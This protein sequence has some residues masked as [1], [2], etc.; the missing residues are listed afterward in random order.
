MNITIFYDLY[1]TIS[2]P[3]EDN[4]SK[5]NLY[6]AIQTIFLLVW[7]FTQQIHAVNGHDFLIHFNLIDIT[8]SFLITVGA[9]NGFIFVSLSV[10]MV[11]VLIYLIKKNTS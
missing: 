6:F 5:T 8:D 7:A 1:Q 4:K 10:L 9:L 3:L 11:L 2:K